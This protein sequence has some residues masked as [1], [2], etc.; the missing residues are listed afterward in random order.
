VV[1]KTTDD[2][3]VVQEKLD[4]LSEQVTEKIEEL[5]GVEARIKRLGEQYLEEKEVASQENLATT[6][7]VERMDAELARVRLESTNGL[8]QSQQ[9]V[10]NATFEYVLPFCLLTARRYEELRRKAAEQTEEVAREMFKVIEDLINFKRH[11]EE[12]LEKVQ[13]LVGEDQLQ[14]ETLFAGTAFE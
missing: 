12:E 8:V 13:Q 2:G 1:H 4:A 10:Q 7:E 5:K 6:D 3:I 11:I 14:V 9:R